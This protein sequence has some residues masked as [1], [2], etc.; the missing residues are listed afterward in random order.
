MAPAGGGLVLYG[1]AGGKRS[2]RATRA[3]APNQIRMTGVNNAARTMKNPR[4]ALDGVGLGLAR[5]GV[6][7][8]RRVYRC[9][10]SLSRGVSLLVCLAELAQ[11]SRRPETRMMAHQ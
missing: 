3:A 6:A 4:R 1:R 2:P 11:V 5:D 9:Y 8:I 10:G 7:V